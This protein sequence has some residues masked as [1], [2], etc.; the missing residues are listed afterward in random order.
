MT[1]AD[2]LRQVLLHDFRIISAIHHVR[3]T[4]SDKGIDFQSYVCSIYTTR[5]E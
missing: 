3:K 4:F 5:S 2:F 1:S